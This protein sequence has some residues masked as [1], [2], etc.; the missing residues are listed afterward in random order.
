MAKTR[1]IE[2]STEARSDI[3]EIL[4]FFNERN[5]NNIYSRKLYGQIQKAVRLIAV[6]PFLGKPTDIE[7]IRVIIF[8]DYLI[9]YEVHAVTVMILTVWD[10]RQN[11]DELKIK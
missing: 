5:G 6:Q 7:N 3:I 2:W 4:S 1:K 9:F 11:P 8:K 10:C